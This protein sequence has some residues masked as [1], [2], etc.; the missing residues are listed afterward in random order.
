MASAP[1]T[2]A[3][4]VISAQNRRRMRLGEVLVSEGL[5]TDAD[6]R[7]ALAKQKLQPGKRLGEVL[8]ELGIV[9]EI[10]IGQTLARKIGLEFMDLRTLTMQSSAVSEIPSKVIQEYTVF[11]IRSDD[12]SITVAM[13]DPLSADALD[14]LRF[15]TRKRIVEV[16]AA[17]SQINQY[18]DQSG[19]SGAGQGEGA[20][21]MAA[22]EDLGDLSQLG[23]SSD[24]VK[25]VN[26]IILDGYRQQASDI[27]IEP[28]GDKDDVLI[29]F[30][31]DGQCHIYR[32]MPPALRES[33]VARL[34][35]MGRLNIAERRKP[36]D[37]KIPFRIGSRNI[38]LRMATLPTAG[39]NEDVVLRILANSEPPP[40]DQMGFSQRNLTELTRIIRQ[41]YGLILC[42]GPTGSGKTTTLHGMLAAINQVNR[43][44]WT[45]EDPVEITQSGLRQVQVHPQIGFTFAAAM[46]AFLRADPDVIM[47][48]EMRDEE[49]AST[50][51]EASLTGHLVFSTLHTNSAPETVTRLVDMGLEP[52][53]FSDALLG[54]LAQR[55]ARRLCTGCR[56]QYSAS[57]TELEEF[58]RYLGRQEIDRLTDSGVL[59]L[60]RAPGCAECDNTGYRGR[61]ALHE[62]LINNETIREAIQQ[63]SGTVQLREHSVLGG[64]TTLLQDGVVKC[65]NGLTDLKQV[66]AV[67]SR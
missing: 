15:S 1:Q 11:P 35:I 56:E 36:Q 10:A 7:S 55:L 8:V 37:G 28:N 20:T 19:V 5:A 2:T 62:L 41:P 25:L 3:N 34:K 44:I 13:G 48:G 24:V 57:A 53:S 67:C 6:I 59:K 21:S 65:I 60:W 26:R 63:Q 43:K 29:R 12:F 14:A 42:V 9:S 47:V 33:L 17:P 51:V 50:G 64:M 39:E 45:A 18:I 16:V 4:Q 54:V 22:E 66:L 30:R 40:L 27:H 38:E 58:C 23:Q 46:R 31:V 32:R 49:T 52:F 61:V